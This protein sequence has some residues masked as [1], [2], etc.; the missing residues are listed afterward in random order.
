L[1]GIEILNCKA[2]SEYYTNDILDSVRSKIESRFYD[3]LP[4]LREM[5]VTFVTVYDDIQFY[6]YEVFEPLWI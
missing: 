5:S 4:N 2:S 1:E 6:G 3:V